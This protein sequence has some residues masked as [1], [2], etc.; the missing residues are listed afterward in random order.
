MLFVIALCLIVLGVLVKDG[1]M[2]F[3]IAGYNTLSP[4]EKAK[5]DIAGIARVFRNG[6]VGMA[7]ILIIGQLLDYF[8]PPSGDISFFIAIT[9]GIPYLLIVTNSKRYKL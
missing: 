3:L 7:V 9:T 8:F 5:Y 1:K 6:M 2:Y 4:A